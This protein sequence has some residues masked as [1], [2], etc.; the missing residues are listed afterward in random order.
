[1][2]RMNYRRP[3][4]AR[5][6]RGGAKRN[7]KGTL[8]FVYLKEQL[9]SGQKT[10]TTRGDNKIQ[11]EVG[12]P[13]VQHVDGRDVEV[14]YLGA[15]TL[16]ETLD[17]FGGLT[18]YLRAEG[19]ISE[20]Q[21]ASFPSGKQFP[22]SEKDLESMFNV[23]PRSKKW[24]ASWVT[25]GGRAHLYELK[26]LPEKKTATS[27]DVGALRAKVAALE[28]M[29]VERGATPAEAE[30]ALRQARQLRER[31]RQA[32]LLE[33]QRLKD[34]EKLAKQRAKRSAEEEEFFKDPQYTDVM[35]PCATKPDLYVLPITPVLLKRYL[36]AVVLWLS[37]TRPVSALVEASD[38]FDAAA[39]RLMQGLEFRFKSGASATIQLPQETARKVVALNLQR[40]QG[41]SWDELKKEHANSGLDWRAL[42]GSAAQMPSFG[43]FGQ[44]FGP[45]GTAESL[46][47]AF[48]VQGR[49][50]GTG[51]VVPASAAGAVSLQDLVIRWAN[52]SQFGFTPGMRGKE[53]ATF[54][55]ANALYDGVP[56]VAVISGSSTSAAGYKLLPPEPGKPPRNVWE[57]LIPLAEAAVAALP[58][59]VAQ[60]ICFLLPPQVLLGSGRRTAEVTANHLY[61]RVLMGAGGAQR[62]PTPLID[63]LWYA[64]RLQAALAPQLQNRLQSL[65]R[66]YEDW[67]A[68][69]ATGIEW[70]E[71]PLHFGMHRP[72]NNVNGYY[73]SLHPVQAWPGMYITVVLR[74]LQQGLSRTDIS[75]LLQAQSY[76]EE[77]SAV[78]TPG[79]TLADVLLTEK[80]VP[81][82]RDVEMEFQEQ[83]SLLTKPLA[84]AAQARKVRLSDLPW[85]ERV[86]VE[87]NQVLDSSLPFYGMYVPV[88][89]VIEGRSGPDRHWADDRLSQSL[90]KLIR[91]GFRRV[92][93]DD[94]SENWRK[95]IPPITLEAYLINRQEAEK[96]L[97]K[98]ESMSS[99]DRV[100]NPGLEG[101]RALL[102]QQT[103]D[104]DGEGT[105]YIGIGPAYVEDRGHP[106]GGYH[107]GY[108]AG[109]GNIPAVLRGLFRVNIAREGRNPTF[110]PLPVAEPLEGQ[111]IEPWSLKGYPYLL[112]S[113]P[114]SAPAGEGAEEGQFVTNWV[115]LPFVG[116]DEDV[117]AVTKE[118]IKA[119][120]GALRG[121]SSAG[122]V[123]EGRRALWE[124]REVEG[125]SA[126]RI[127]RAVRRVERA[128]VASRGPFRST[129]IYSLVAR[130]LQGKKTVRTGWEKSS[131]TSL[132]NTAM[133]TNWP[134]ILMEVNN[135]RLNKG[136]PLLPAETQA[137]LPGSAGYSVELELEALE[138]IERLIYTP[139][140]KAMALTLSGT[141]LF[142]PTLNRLGGES[143][144]LSS[145]LDPE[146]QQAL[147]AVE[148]T[149]RRR[150]RARRTRRDRSARGARR[151][152]LSDDDW[153]QVQSWAKSGVEPEDPSV[154]GWSSPKSN[155]EMI[156]SVRAFF[157]PA[158]NLG[159]LSTPERF[160][161]LRT[162]GGNLFPRFKQGETKEDLEAE[163]QEH[164]LKRGGL[165]IDLPEQAGSY[166][167]RRAQLSAQEGRELALLRQQ[168]KRRSKVVSP[169]GA[170][171][172]AVRNAVQL[173]WKD[174]PSPL[175]AKGTAW[176][177]IGPPLEGQTSA[178]IMTFRNGAHIDCDVLTRRDQPFSQVLGRV[179]QSMTL[180]LTE[181]PV[182]LERIRF[183]GLAQVGSPKYRVLW[184]QGRV[185]NPETL[186]RQ[187][188]AEEPQE[189]PKLAKGT[190]GYE[191]AQKKAMRG[192]YD[193]PPLPTASPTGAVP[194]STPSTSP[195]PPPFPSVFTTPDDWDE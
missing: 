8:N 24:V 83:E 73:G 88:R 146:V 48:G 62:T 177:V 21:T 122:E 155:E 106:E 115:T 42:D 145:L 103:V 52:S 29:R 130:I 191:A 138:A 30:T 124:G 9:L 149:G 114:V 58:T 10:L 6:S 143:D 110:A 40:L 112:A 67:T 57:D 195:T 156:E 168:S 136:Q 94:T 53:F 17:K 11:A 79:L 3:R 78:H 14:T 2:S 16:K 194:A 19:M 174:A 89:S 120:K 152:P 47:S 51:L 154:L 111:H 55:K 81:D 147:Y 186:L 31:I 60:N 108:S 173:P 172:L 175:L 180:W 49:A 107:T 101:V 1:M 38:S 150:R 193:V 98:L 64:P 100:E 35:P 166:L 76:G 128:R 129:G 176:V 90:L 182:R 68:K 80:K 69:Q 44:V 181:K 102:K 56:V 70:A 91:V 32:E 45:I 126:R 137:P 99:E 71:P 116:S 148:N 169:S 123:K 92:W 133:E 131:A 139:S 87:L 142:H 18:G 84:P 121:G 36:N 161:E 185:L 43:I 159:R 118:Y 75:E 96:F 95:V 165:A 178:R 117:S 20:E 157:P 85:R 12:V 164:F 167:G 28:E 82:V 125:S 34:E 13:F 192:A 41:K 141:R 144:Q 93:E 119:V 23:I 183:V 5:R 26:L 25:G 4:P 97:P 37:E 27:F 105:W 59:S 171:C 189:D 63:F 72:Y 160:N 179:L 190:A 127:G 140:P 50:S 22:T 151:N 66:A 61:Q 135:Q 33:K 7:P 184:H 170:A 46:R 132:L 104:V 134:E 65:V 163:L 74:Y 187:A 86:T 113:V 15:L 109:K 158:A 153:R 188:Y 39:K 54:Y 162:K 77:G